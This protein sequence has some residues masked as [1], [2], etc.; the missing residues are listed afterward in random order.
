MD[1]PAGASQSA[2]AWLPRPRGD[3][4][5]GEAVTLADARAPPP[6]RGWTSVGANS[7][8]S[9]SGS[10]AHAGMDPVL[11]PRRCP[12]VGLP[13]PR[14]D[15]P[16]SMPT[17][18][19][20]SPAPPPTRGWT[21][22]G[23]PGDRDDGGS[24]AHAGMDRRPGCSSARQSGLPRPRGDGPY[25][26]IFGRTLYRAPPP[27]RGWT[28]DAG[29]GQQRPAGSPAHAGM[30]HGDLRYL[31][32]GCWLPRPRGDGPPPRPLRFVRS[33]APPPTRGWT[34]ATNHTGF[35]RGGSPAHAGMDLR[36]AGSTRRACGLPRPRGDGPSGN[37]G[38][39]VTLGA[40]PPTRGWT[41]A[42]T[43]A[44]QLSGGSPAHAGMDPRPAVPR[45]CC[46]GLPR[47]RGDGPHSW[48][49]TRWS[50]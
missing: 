31:R 7:T 42:G 26:D 39:D 43:G 40:P 37:L 25:Y 3:G 21:C 14:G 30:D 10:P 33:R 50:T 13:R 17:A 41:V 19:I 28:P 29:H 1:P 47:P 5:T 23:R 34:H 6:T 49:R 22:V 27:T 18:A 12:G 20:C 45:D 36:T 46:R 38:G 35:G 4:P 32:P 2:H 15:G 16:L 44:H 24:P 8:L 11:R 48:I 9:A